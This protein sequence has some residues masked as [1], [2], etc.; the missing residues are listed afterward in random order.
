MFGFVLKK[1]SITMDISENN[2]G[3]DVFPPEYSYITISRKD[4]SI[5]LLLWLG[6][7]K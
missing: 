7:L 5:S 2:E 6:L 4:R 3:K 1:N